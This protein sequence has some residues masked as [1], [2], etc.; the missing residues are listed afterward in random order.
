MLV[1]G[2]VAMIGLTVRFFGSVANKGVTFH[3]LDVRRWRKEGTGKKD[4][5]RGRG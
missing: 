5:S 1:F 3:D 2:S 4:L